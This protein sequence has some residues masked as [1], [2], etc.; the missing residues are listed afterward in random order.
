MTF[1]MSLRKIAYH[2]P[3]RAKEQQSHV[4]QSVALR[5][6]ENIEKVL[7]ITTLDF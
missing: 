2:R 3:K 1:L 5:V 4:R 6:I 7:Q